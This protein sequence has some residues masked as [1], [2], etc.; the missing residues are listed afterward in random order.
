MKSKIAIASVLKPVIE[1]RAYEKIGKSLANSDKYEV[2]ILGAFPATRYE[3]HRIKLYPISV[4]SGMINRILNSWKLFFKL[5]GIRPQL[6]IIGTHELLFIG[7]LLRLIT[8]CR[9]VYDIQENYLR[10]LIFQRNYSWG[11]RH[12]LAAIIRVR[13]KLYSPLYDHYILAEKCYVDELDFIDKK[14]TV[15]ENKF[16]QPKGVIGTSPQDKTSLLISGTLGYESGTLE[17]IE[18]FKHLPEDEFDLII[19]GHCP[20]RRFHDAI[21]NSIDGLSNVTKR[22]S[23]VPVPHN[24]ILNL[25]G[26][27]TLGLLPYKANKSTVNKIPTK[28]Y[29]YIGLGIP[30]LISPNPIWEEMINQYKAGMIVDFKSPP[31]IRLIHDS[32]NSIDKRYQIDLKDVMWKSEEKKLLSLVEALI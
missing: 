18:F 15:L 13:E 29:E 8:G 9:L 10:N 20:N 17:A 31:S 11:I 26:N 7:V 4:N 32:I 6:L 1:P 22:V 27:K 3:H 30:V 14:Y 25:I 28:L 16:V 5:F 21:L 24:E 19:V 23:M 12:L 2:H